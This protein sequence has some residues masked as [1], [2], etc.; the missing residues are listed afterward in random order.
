MC[1][2]FHCNEMSQTDCFT[3]SNIPKSLK[4]VKWFEPNISCKT[5][6][7]IMI[8]QGIRTQGCGIFNIRFI[9]SKAITYESRYSRLDWVKF[10][11]DTALN[12]F[13]LVHSWI[14]WLICQ[15]RDSLKGKMPAYGLWNLFRI[16]DKKTVTYFPSHTIFQKIILIKY[17]KHFAL[18]RAPKREQGTHGNC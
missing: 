10:V 5:N 13:Y 1:K 17:Y 15:H 11:K 14:P 6:W 4:L 8:R 18:L 9:N 3:K 16:L 7:W 12:K 2:F